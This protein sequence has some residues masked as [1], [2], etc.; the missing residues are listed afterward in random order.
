MCELSA[1]GCVLSPSKCELAAVVCED[2]PVGCELSP[3]VYVESHDGCVLADDVYDV[4]AARRDLA[5]EARAVPADVCAWP[6]G[7]R[8]SLD[9]GR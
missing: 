7:D 1:V 2:I 8:E 9:D 5:Y 6:V 4:A 3:V